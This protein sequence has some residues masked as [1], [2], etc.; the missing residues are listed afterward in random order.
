[1]SDHV[2]GKQTGS[3]DLRPLDCSCALAAAHSRQ[4]LA[5]AVGP[6]LLKLEELGVFVEQQQQRLTDERG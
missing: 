6:R 5:S 2:A 3:L 4:T 1:M